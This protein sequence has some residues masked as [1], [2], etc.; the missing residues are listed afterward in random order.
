MIEV[1]PQMSFQP[2][3]SFG[4]KS[5]ISKKDRLIKL[6]QK[7]FQID[8]NQ[9]FSQVVFDYFVDTRHYRVNTVGKP[10]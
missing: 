4:L 2:E 8:I 6:F 7:Y 1:M 3:S 5:A 9:Q 10:H